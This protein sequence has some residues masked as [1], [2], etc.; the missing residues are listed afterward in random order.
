MR[1]YRHSILLICLAGF[2]G[3]PLRAQ[4]P[5]LTVE[6][7]GKQLRISAPQLHFLEGK[8]SEQLHNGASVT[9]EITLALSAGGASGTRLQE[10]FIVSYDLW[11]EKFSVVQA[12][13]AGRSAS[14]LSAAAAEAWCLDSMPLPVPSF[15]AE[16]AFTVKLACS[17]L[18][19][20][21]TAT[22]N[23]PILTLA[24]LIDV[25]SRKKRPEPPHWEAA[26]A[27]LRLPE[28]KER[29]RP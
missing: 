12:G 23:N 28:V 20:E 22:E 13:P 15:G 29:K 8:A 21:V 5:Q 2:L 17:M 26:S 1:P 11:E 6:R 19:P 7:Q 27:P 9:F 24:S 14:H 4:S 18:D 3:L 25:F 10:R 16:K